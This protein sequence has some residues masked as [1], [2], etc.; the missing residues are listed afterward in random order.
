METTKILIVDDKAENITAMRALIED[1]PADIFSADS[2]LDALSLVLDHEFALALIDVNMPGMS[3]FELAKLIRGTERT[4]HIPIIFVTA[5]QQEEGAILEGYGQGAVDFLFKPLDPHI[6]RSKV[7]VFIELDRHRKHQVTQM[8]ELR[9]LKIKADEAAQVKSNFLAN[10]SH[11]IRTPLS[12]MLGFGE[13]LSDPRATEKERRTY[14][15]A[16]IR[17]GRHLSALVDDILDL[18]KIEAGHLEIEKNVIV[19]KDLLRDLRTLFEPRAQKKG[20]ALQFKC[21][22]SVPETFTSDPDRLRQILNNVIG[23][24]V[25]F[26]DIGT[27]TVSVRFE[28]KPNTSDSILL[29]EVRDTGCGLDLSYK[30]RIFQPFTQADTSTS[31]KYGGTGLGLSISKYLAEALGGDLTLEAA[32]IAKGCTFLLK[33]DAGQTSFQSRPLATFKAPL[34]AID[35]HEKHLDELRIL[36]VDDVEDNR[37]LLECILANYGARTLTASDGHEAIE[38]AL[39]SNPDLILMDVQMPGMDGMEATKT[40]RSKGYMKPILALT[41][42]VMQEARERCLEAGYNDH[43]PKPINHKELLEKITIFAEQSKVCTG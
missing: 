40:L 10:M 35:F 1:E 15:N 2:G 27:I 33:I 37:L 5:A 32:E 41:A 3:G 4:R 31:R 19:T 26:T 38:K 18:S 29:F 43:L 12:A 39:E 42:H 28:Q 7:R 9:R 8:E 23:N 30:N 24:A 17:N 13:L 21:E 11:E 6:V 14:T 25:K 22:K 34:V 20:I 36:L 16:I